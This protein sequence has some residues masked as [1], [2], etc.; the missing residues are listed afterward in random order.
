MA[1]RL[2]DVEASILWHNEVDIEVDIEAGEGP[3][4]AARSLDD[5]DS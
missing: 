2:E 4:V 3:A 5:Q 1:G